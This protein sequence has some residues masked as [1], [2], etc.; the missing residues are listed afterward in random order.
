[1]KLTRKYLCPLISLAI[2]FVITVCF[3]AVTHQHWWPRIS[4]ARVMLGRAQVEAAVYRSDDRQILL[5][6]DSGDRY[7]IRGGDEVMI[8]DNTF[9]QLP[10]YAFAKRQPPPGVP[11]SKHEVK[12]DFDAHLEVAQGRIA[13][14]PEPRKRLVLEY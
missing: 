3:V 10:G 5:I 9:Y 4:E 2:I 13:F 14:N 1:M 7:L 8:A 11:I 12:T 6:L